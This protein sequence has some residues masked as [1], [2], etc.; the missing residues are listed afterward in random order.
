[1]PGTNARNPISALRSP[2][3][4]LLALSLTMK[5]ALWSVVTSADPARFLGADTKEYLGPARALL[6]TGYFA[7]SPQH[8]DELETNRTPGYPLFLA[9]GMLLFGES[10]PAIVFL[11][12]LTSLVSLS[13]V[14]ST[15]RLLWD[16]RVATL[17]GLLFALDP[18]SLGYTEILMTETLFACLVAAAMRASA[19]LVEKREWSFEAVTIGMLVAAAAY[20]RPIGYYLGPAMALAVLAIGLTKRWPLRRIGSTAIGILLPCVVLLGGWQLRNLRATG[21]VAFSPIEGRMVYWSRAAWITARLDHIPVKDARRRLAESAGNEPSAEWATVRLVAAH[22][23]LFVTTSAYRAL[24]MMCGPGE[25]RLVWLLEEPTLRAPGLDL[26]HYGLA[27]FVKRWVRPPRWQLAFFLFAA[28]YLALVDFGLLRR[29]WTLL[30]ERR[31]S[32]AEVL[33]W[34]VVGYFLA[35]GVSSSRF[36]VPLMPAASI[37]AAAGLRRSPMPSPAT[38]ART[39]VV[40][41]RLGAPIPQGASLQRIGCPVKRRQSHQL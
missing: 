9:G 1:L 23:L 4:G 34:V 14:Y 13:L 17:G 27:E 31:I 19:S 26:H 29:L 10:L 32:A 39:S 20:V 16:T 8:P 38:S 22:P 6:E 24:R 37:L 28:G 36:R 41:R 12:I 7:R 3:V 11:Q 21:S 5:V 40:A 18:V 35:T 15:A 25:H 30:R 2:L 33:L